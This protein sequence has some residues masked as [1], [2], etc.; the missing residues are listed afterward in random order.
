MLILGSSSVA[1]KELLHSVGI[2]PD[3][4]VVPDVDESL[5][6]SEKPQSYVKRIAKEKADSIYSCDKSFLVTAD[7]IVT[8]G[9]KILLKTF[10]KGVAQEYLGA[11]SGRRHNVLTAFC[12]KHNGLVTLNV[13]KTSLK[14]KLLSKTE[15]NNYITSGE[16]VG[17]AGA[18]RIQGIAKRFFPFISGCFSNV[19]GLPIPK[20]INVL[21]G[22]GF[23]Q[24]HN[25]KRNSY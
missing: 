5:G 22:L 23:F 12:V 4:I 15:I 9:P 10:D 18:Y 7:T 11:L 25:E 24:N 13:V 16:W 1:R 8:L 6:D 21:S 2:F 17:C 20:L 14:M 3:E 19:V